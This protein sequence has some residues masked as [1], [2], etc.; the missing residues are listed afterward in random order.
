MRRLEKSQG[1]EARSRNEFGDLPLHLACYGGQ[2][3][4]KPAVIRALI[5]A[6]PGSVREENKKG[7][8]PLELAAINYRRDHPARAQVLALLRWHRPGDS[9]LPV[10]E[11]NMFGEELFSNEPPANLFLASD[12]CV[13]CLERPSSVAVL[14]CGHV[15][16]CLQCLPATMKKGICPVDRV[17]TSRCLQV[18]HKLLNILI[19]EIMLR[20]DSSALAQPT[21]DDTHMRDISTL[22][23]N[24]QILPN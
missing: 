10:E 15:C 20:G 8:D 9:P 5:D 14:P 21:Y 12:V 11:M 3:P 1:G 23:L 18:N 16:L 2:A 19:G 6:Y 13:V 22:F 4:S 24:V 17:E 7:R